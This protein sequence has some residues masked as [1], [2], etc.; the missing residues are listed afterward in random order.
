MDSAGG[1][2]FHVHHLA[3]FGP[4]VREPNTFKGEVVLLAFQHE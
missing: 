1:I 2:Q 3:W 4:G